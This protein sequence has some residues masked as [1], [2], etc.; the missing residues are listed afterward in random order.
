MELIG[1]CHVSALRLEAERRAREEEELRRLEEEERQR[2]E[3]KAR[4]KEA[5]RVGRS[6]VVDGGV[7]GTWQ[8]ET[9]GSLRRYFAGI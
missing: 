1:P 3:E 2:E 7:R 4:K 5:Q 8:L 6:G 9:T